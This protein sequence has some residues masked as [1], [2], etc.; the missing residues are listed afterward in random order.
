MVNHRLGFVPEFLDFA[1]HERGQLAPQQ[2]GLLL[3]TLVV[4]TLLMPSIAT[5]LGRWFWWPQVVHPRG[6]NARRQAHPGAYPQAFPHAQPMGG[7][8]ATPAPAR[9]PAHA[10]PDDVTAVVTRG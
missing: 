5:M 7:P 6:D 2:F 10:M 8:H 3:D 4:R 1:R 9:Q